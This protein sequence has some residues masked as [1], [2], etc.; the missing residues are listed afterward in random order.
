MD[1]DGEGRVSE[2]I[3]WTAHEWDRGLIGAKFTREDV[4][5]ILHILLSRRDRRDSV[6]WLPNEDGV[7][8]V[9]SGCCIAR[10]LSRAMNGMEGSFGAQNRGSIWPRLWKLHLTN[11]IKIFWVEGMP[12]HP[13][14]E[15]KFGSLKNYRRWCM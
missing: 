4:E 8:S 1:E 13:T 6:V 7:C 2:L 11:K 3:D 10:L 15:R 5:A 12:G 14:N 9:K